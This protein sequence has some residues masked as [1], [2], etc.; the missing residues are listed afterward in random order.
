M[1][2]TLEQICEGQERPLELLNYAGLY[3]IG[4]KAFFSQTG[5][6]KV[7]LEIEKL[8]PTKVTKPIGGG[9]GGGARGE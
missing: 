6:I 2:L 7:S 3:E 4:R 1:I 9:W 5:A 8:V